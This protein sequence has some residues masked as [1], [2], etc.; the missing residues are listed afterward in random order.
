LTITGHIRMRFA[1]GFPDPSFPEDILFLR[2]QQHA[3]NIVRTR[4]AMILGILPDQSAID[5]LSRALTDPNSEIRVAA[6]RA[7]ATHGDRVAPQVWLS[8]L[9]DPR[10]C[11]WA[12][13]GLMAHP[14][15]A[16]CLPQNHEQQRRIAAYITSH[17]GRVTPDHREI[18][19]NGLGDT[20]MTTRMR[21]V[22]ALGYCSAQAHELLP[23]LMPALDDPDA[24]VRCAAIRAVVQLGGEVPAMT[25]QC[26]LHDDAT[27]DASALALGR[28]GDPHAIAIISAALQSDQE[29]T[30]ENA[31]SWLRTGRHTTETIR[32]IVRHLPLSVIIRALTDP[33]W[34]ASY[35]WAECVATLGA[36]VPFTQVESLLRHAD[37]AVRIAALHVL[38]C[39]GVRPPITPPFALLDDP[40]IT[41][42]RE[43]VETLLAFDV[44]IEQ[45][46]PY[47]EPEHPAVAQALARRGSLEAVEILLTLLTQGDAHVQWQAAH[48]LTEVPGPLPAAA[49]IDALGER[50][51][52]ISVQVLEVLAR[53]PG[54]LRD[55]LSAII[56]TLEGGRRWVALEDLF[57]TN[58]VYS[59][60][61]LV[62]AAPTMHAYAISQLDARRCSTQ[63][64]AL[65]TVEKLPA[66][67]RE[68]VEWLRAASPSFS[69]RNMAR[70]RLDFQSS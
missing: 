14:Q 5:A 3:T 44:P 37:E 40:E 60:R 17:R 49:L 62:A 51:D 41:V 67:A 33:Y 12:I 16:Q 58:L 32:D 53:Q 26:L 9:D 2:L 54:A 20:Q 63:C 25:R 48:A 50:D 69:V 11:S 64:A 23:M 46:L 42:R 8:L 30:R 36:D 70:R 66:G 29:F 21:C 7:L 22:V 31:V 55:H 18:L 15:D 10:M 13:Q 65:L 57:A 19:L 6:V 35:P 45:L 52:Q 28:L 1:L 38:A 39:C 4:A 47:L 59:L 27:R 68:R 24:D 43:A 61:G 56:S 34:P